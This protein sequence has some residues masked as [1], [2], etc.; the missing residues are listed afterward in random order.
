MSINFWNFWKQ[1]EPGM[2]IPSTIHR[3]FYIFFEF[4]PPA[5]SQINVCSLRLKKGSQ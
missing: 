3:S 2:F 1:I 4:W 5:S